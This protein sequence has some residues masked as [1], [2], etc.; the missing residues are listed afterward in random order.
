MP[1][2]NFDIFRENLRKS[3]IINELTAVELSE[4]AGLRQK[5][6]VSDIED[7]R[8][9]PS[10][11]EV[12]ALCDVLNESIELMMKKKARMKLDFFF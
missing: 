5:K 3:R 2:I 4:K 10:L 9:K 1:E 6:R 11:D 7:G 12:Y 8:G